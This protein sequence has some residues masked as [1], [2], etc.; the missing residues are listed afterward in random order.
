M[1]RLLYTILL[2]HFF[3]MSV[4]AQA[5]IVK[6]Y[7]Q[8][9]TTNEV[10]VMWEVYDVGNG[11][12][13]FGLDPFNITE[14]VLSDSN[15]GSG[16]T[17]IHT[18]HISNLNIGT[19]YYYKVHMQG[20]Q[21]SQLY[22]FRT[23]YPSSHEKATQFIAI[24]DMQRDGSHPN[25]FKDIIEDGIIPIISE[26]VG[27]SLN[28]LEAVL[29]PGDL[30]PTGGNYNQWKDYFFNPSDS[31]FPYVPIYPVPGNHEYGN[32]GLPN[33]IKYFSM[34]ENGPT[35]LADQCWYKD[36]S[37]VRIIGLNSNSETADKNLQLAWLGELLD[38]TC[39]KEH[40]DFVFAELHHPYKSEL[41]TP[42][43]SDF[44]GMVIDSLEQF[45][46]FCA[47]PSIHFFGH[48]HG[49]S[50]GQSRDHKHLWVN[51]A[52]AGGAIDNW[53]EF[54]NADYDEFVKSQDEYGFVLIEVEAGEEPKFSL[55][56][57]SL[58]DQDIVLD[59]IVRDSITIYKK[60]W[61]PY[62]PINIFPQDGDTIQASCLTLRASEFAGV[63]DSIQAAHW[64]IAKSNNFVDSIIVS[65]WFQDENYY[66][67]QNLQ[68]NDLLI[69]TEVNSIGSNA[70]YDW[71][72]RYR[73]QN[74]EWS[75]WSES[76]SIYV[77]SS[78]DT[79]SGN[80]VENEGAE[81]GI[82]FWMGDI[83]SIQNGACNSVQPY[84]GTH[85]FAVGGVCAN[86][87]SFGL[88]HQIIDL[89]PYQ[90]EISAGEA[91]LNFGGFMR[92]YNGTDIPEMYV[93]FYSSGNLIFTTNTIS[94]NTGNWVF[95]EATV[96]IPALTDSC[97]LNLTG[98]RNAGSDND[99]YFDDLQC[100][101]LEGSC[102]SCYGLSD[103]DFDQDGFCSDFD[104]DDSDDTV[105]PGALEICDG[106]DNNCNG[107]ADYGNTVTW[108]GLGS[109]NLWGNA[110]NWDQMM[111]PLSCQLVIINNPD[112]I[113]IDNVF[114]C[115]GLEMNTSSILTIQE[116]S[117]LKIDS[118]QEVGS[119]PASI[120]GMLLVNGKWEVR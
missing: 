76:T 33:F 30:V 46:S 61:V 115:R 50:R 105:Y 63:S 84:L 59:N 95:I 54:P 37:N 118:N 80:L 89:S 14:T 93:E 34:P 78:I 38:S 2:L 66:F 15:T 55:R 40:I 112:S 81:N 45:T 7:L 85:N 53:G 94:S 17:R 114:E 35:G 18:A 100:Y 68:A 106:K 26:E 60:E 108:T 22:T 12:L 25:K 47:K 1:A 92:S 107:I 64:Q 91:V 88:A 8:N 70:S 72:V 69:D 6:P 73:D 23:N 96:S 10:T 117:Y 111:I 83:E 101:I 11:E 24:S 62:K 27:P 97:L 99:S 49:Y 48:T 56:R 109:D 116:D 71:R 86:E 74:L 52:T 87:S 102:L 39:T 13:R 28:D 77:E 31:L 3:G 51:V 44:T 58:G 29:I 119:I 79:L 4:H 9:I 113:L 36:I 57:Y 5:I 98:T 120:N 104:C 43:E 41:W 21:E 110:N 90:T 75:D 65:Q 42:G 16:L 20:G 82:S 19:K 103:V 32:G 67:E